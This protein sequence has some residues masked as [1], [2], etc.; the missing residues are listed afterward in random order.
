MLGQVLNRASQRHDGPRCFCLP[1]NVR[2]AAATAVLYASVLVSATVA[3]AGY[4]E[5]A[6]VGRPPGA[7]ELARDLQAARDLVPR[8]APTLVVT[9]AAMPLDYDFWLGL[10]N[11]VRI[12][13]AWTEDAFLGSPSAAAAIY[14]DVARAGALLTSDSLAEALTHSTCAVAAGPVA[15]RG[16]RALAGPRLAQIGAAGVVEV[17]RILPP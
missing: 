6:T 5:R 17:F 10:T 2:A 8:N 13:V 15:T 7:V 3:L 16:V 9:T 14:D 4:R 1:P 12:L 11:P